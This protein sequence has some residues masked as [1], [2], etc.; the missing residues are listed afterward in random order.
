MECL[1][2][3]G[4]EINFNVIPMTLGMTVQGI[5]ILYGCNVVM[6]FVSQGNVH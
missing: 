5:S 3:Y 6:V 4:A 2:E 1:H